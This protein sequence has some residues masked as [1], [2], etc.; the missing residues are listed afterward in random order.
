MDRDSVL[1]SKG[2]PDR[3]VREVGP[4]EGEMGAFGFLLNAHK[5][6]N[7]CIRLREFM[8]VGMRALLVPVT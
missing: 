1:S 7:I 2:P 6:K 8:P 4:D 3:R 5:W